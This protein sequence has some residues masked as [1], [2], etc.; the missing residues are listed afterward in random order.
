[1]DPEAGKAK[2]K[3]YHPE[4]AFYFQTDITDADKVS[5]ACDAALEAIPNGSLFGGVHCAAIAPGR[6]WDHNLKNS[7]PVSCFWSS[8]VIPNQSHD[9]SSKK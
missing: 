8:P 7:I 4:R 6:K 3:E 1:M 5:A 2:V 9:S